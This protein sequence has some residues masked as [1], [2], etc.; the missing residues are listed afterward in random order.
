MKGVLSWLKS[1]VVL[2]ILAVLIVVPL[3]VAWFFSSGMNR[4]LVEG[5]QTDAQDA[6][7]KV[8]GVN[9][10]YEV[11]PFTADQEAVSESSPPNAVKTEH[12]RAELESRLAQMETVKQAA[13][14]Y[15]RKD[16]GVLVEGLFPQP[17]GESQLKRNEMARRA[18]ASGTRESAYA[19]LLGRL[20]VR[21]PVDG[22]ELA[23]LISVQR[24][25]KVAEMTGD[26][27][28]QALTDEQREQIDAEMLDLRISRYRTH[29]MDTVYYGRLD[30][31]PLSVPREP[32]LSPPPLEQCFAWQFDYWLI[33]D[34]TRALADANA[35]LDATGV[36]GNAVEGVVKRVYSIEIDTPAFAAVGPG[37]DAP[38]G[39]RDD[40]GDSEGG[41]G[42]GGAATLTGRGPGSSGLYDVRN[43]K[44]SLLVSSAK[45]P[46]LLDSL[47]SSNFI[48]VLDLDLSEVD[49]WAELEQGYY[50]GSDA[51]V[52]AELEVEV[53]FLRD[54]TAPFMPE[55][56]KQALGISTGGTDDE[57]EG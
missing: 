40:F 2:V 33:E 6:L 10:N 7:R 3:P 12:F 51:V 19:Q 54:W 16:R 53:L 24:E 50:I 37:G 55:G 4:S 14:E 15:N 8:Q 46:A 26:Q 34:L 45:L 9:V 30:V 35:R 21:P 38:R 28:E 11:P 36:G 48:T 44:L 52:R 43:A 5:R 32:A 20:R 57:G 13:I 42:S 56:V 17:T 39:G 23:S 1:N 41:G 22:E 18:V 25:R 31:L 27:G 29:A 47:G 49:P